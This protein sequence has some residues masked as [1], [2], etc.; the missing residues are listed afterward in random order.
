MISSWDELNAF[1]PSALCSESLRLYLSWSMTVSPPLSWNSTLK[2]VRLS[3]GFQDEETLELHDYC[4]TSNE[5][6]ALSKLLSLRLST[7]LPDCV[8]R[9]CFMAV[10]SRCWN[11]LNVKMHNEWAE[12]IE[13][14]PTSVGLASIESGLDESARRRRW[15]GA[16][17]LIWWRGL[18]T[19]ISF[20]GR[21]REERGAIDPLQGSQLRP[22]QL[23]RLDSHTPP[24]G[25][26][27]A[28][29]GTK[30]EYEAP[31]TD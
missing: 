15:K 8:N 3:Q 27:N 22:Q 18:T 11:D 10:M 23:T 16:V 19:S 24:R 12:P 4:Y 28:Q 29:R 2:I 1:M 31:L 14:K 20:L 26:A 6:N 25:K 21:H 7:C 9:D 30:I 5:E 17:P 13:R